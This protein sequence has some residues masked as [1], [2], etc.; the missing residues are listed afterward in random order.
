M[1]LLTTIGPS[2][3]KACSNKPSAIAASGIRI[4]VDRE[5]SDSGLLL[6]GF[7]ST[8]ISH[9]ARAGSLGYGD[10]DPPRLV[11]GPRRR[12]G[13]FAEPR[14]NRHSASLGN[15]IVRRGTSAGP[16][17]PNIPKPSIQLR[18]TNEKMATTPAS[19]PSADRLRLLIRQ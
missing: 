11:L 2:L 19:S 14:R 18:R 15:R 12:D 3:R 4:R 8:S 10:A 17:G 9:P 16:R 7:Q 13:V 6:V 5:L 1:R